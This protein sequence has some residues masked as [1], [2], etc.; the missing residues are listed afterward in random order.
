MHV[1]GLLRVAVAVDVATGGVVVGIVT[2]AAAVAVGGAVA[3]DVVE[4]MRRDWE[5]LDVEHIEFETCKCSYCVLSLDFLC[6][7]LAGGCW[8]CV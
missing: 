3:V 7:V 4:L 6:I 8:T 1:V 5:Q 2:A